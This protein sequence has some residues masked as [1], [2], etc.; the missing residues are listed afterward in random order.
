M[1]RLNETE[2]LFDAKTEEV[3]DQLVIPCSL[4]GR[5]RVVLFFDIVVIFIFLPVDSCIFTLKTNE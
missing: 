1:L 5:R 4:R 3:M 2:N